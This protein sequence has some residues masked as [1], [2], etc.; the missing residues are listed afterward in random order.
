MIFV[1]KCLRNSK[2]SITFTKNLVYLIC[3]CFTLD[4]EPNDNINR[5]ILVERYN[6]KKSTI[7]W[8]Y[9][10]INF[11][12]MQWKNVMYIWHYHISNIINHLT[13]TN[14]GRYW[15]ITLWPH[16][17]YHYWVVAAYGWWYPSIKRFTRFIISFLCNE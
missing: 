5:E 3:L 15:Y 12:S 8:Y 7:I 14:I 16:K 10:W 4:F 11:M 2:C 17:S 1:N 6:Q 13:N 9:E